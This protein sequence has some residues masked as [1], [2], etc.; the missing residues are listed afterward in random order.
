[1]ATPTIQGSC[2]MPSSWGSDCIALGKGLADKVRDLFE[3]CRG[4]LFY[5]SEEEGGV[6]TDSGL[7]GL[8][9]AGLAPH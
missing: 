4:A 8:G 5:A 1:G 3:I 6:E 9:G 7:W 2:Q